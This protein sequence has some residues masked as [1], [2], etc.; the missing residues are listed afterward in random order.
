M[1]S[2]MKNGKTLLYFHFNKIKKWPETGFQ[3]T[4]LSQKHFRNFS[5]TA[6]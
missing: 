6:H 3:S 4:A 2:A 1:H 5:H